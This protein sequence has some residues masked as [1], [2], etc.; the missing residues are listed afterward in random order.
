MSNY[1]RQALHFKEIVR[2]E[3]DNLYYDLKDYSE[4]KKFLTTHSKINFLNLTKEQR[5][6][7]IKK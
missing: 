5:Y 1:N 2:K 7:Y 3:I 6:R 4:K